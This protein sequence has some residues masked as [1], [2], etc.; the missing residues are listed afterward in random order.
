MKRL[1]VFTTFI[2]KT[3]KAFITFLISTRLMMRR[4]TSSY[5]IMFPTIASRELSIAI[6]VT[7]AII[8]SIL[9][10]VS[11]TVGTVRRID[12]AANGPPIRRRRPCIWISVGIIE[13]KTICVHAV[14]AYLRIDRFLTHLHTTIFY[15]MS[16]IM[17]LCSRTFS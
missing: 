14:A 13:W 8:G 9:L 2:V 11:E 6:C 12:Y 17:S 1:W 5:T 4:Y 10:I 15:N 7:T 3:I 16:L